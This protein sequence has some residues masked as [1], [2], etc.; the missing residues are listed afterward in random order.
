[1]YA[2]LAAQG[3]EPLYVSVNNA[4]YR[5]KWRSFVVENK[6]RG[7]HYLASTTVQQ[8]LTKLL[9]RGIPR[10][11][12]FDAQGRLVDDDL[13]FPSSGETLQQRIRQRLGT[14]PLPH[15]G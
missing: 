11:L 6:L 14:R 15:K 12:L 9:A 10:Y 1:L 2:F 4:N 8:S 13:P 7:S 5:A 3:I